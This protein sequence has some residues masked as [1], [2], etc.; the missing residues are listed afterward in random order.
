MNH[1]NSLDYALSVVLRSGLFLAITI[2]LYGACL[3]LWNTNSEV[4]DYRVFDGEPK[5]LKV[6]H[7]I[8]EGVFQNDSLAVIQ[9]GII[10][11]IATP[12]LRVFSCLILFALE[13]DM[14]Y[15]VISA[16]VLVILLYANYY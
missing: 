3:L 14:L 12:I 15:V 11:L 5:S 13:K 10:I 6:A 16:I 8:L 4:I 1:S 9:L 2:V 7:N